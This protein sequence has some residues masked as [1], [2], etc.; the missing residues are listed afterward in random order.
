MHAREVQNFSRGRKKLEKSVRLD[1]PVEIGFD[2][3][4]NLRQFA[5][6]FTLFILKD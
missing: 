4:S 3:A 6:Y 2:N 1:F 5:V